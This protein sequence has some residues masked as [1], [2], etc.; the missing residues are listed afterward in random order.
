MNPKYMEFF[1][2]KIASNYHNPESEVYGINSYNYLFYL[3]LR[4]WF[5]FIVLDYAPPAVKNSLIL[6]YRWNY[7]NLIELDLNNYIYPNVDRATAEAIFQEFK[8]FINDFNELRIIENKL[9]Q[10]NA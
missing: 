10:L 9:L 1:I 6:D 3:K 2:D 5:K 8:G 4:E 7:F